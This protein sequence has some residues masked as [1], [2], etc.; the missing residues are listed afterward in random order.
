MNS[1][2]LYLVLNISRC[3]I[4]I[5]LN[6]PRNTSKSYSCSR[7]NVRR[8]SLPHKSLPEPRYPFSY[9][10]VWRKALFQ[11]FADTFNAVVF[12]FITTIQTE[13]YICVHSH[14]KVYAVIPLMF[15]FLLK[16]NSKQR[17]TDRCDNLL[18]YRLKTQY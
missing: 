4:S 6:V 16:C 1:S 12:C 3:A 15:F 18:I 17:K 7:V 2:V 13:M 10:P 5:H 9:H 11:P 8:S 14:L